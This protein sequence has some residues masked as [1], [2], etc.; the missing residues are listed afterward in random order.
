MLF[1]PEAKIKHKVGFTIKRLDVG[2]INFHYYKNRIISLIKNL[3]FPNLLYILPLHLV[4]SVGISIAFL[5][6]GQLKSAK[7]IAKAV[8]WNL[9]NITNTLKNR[10]I[11]Q[12]LRAVSDQQVFT[13]L[14]KPT[15]IRKFILDFK[16]VSDDLRKK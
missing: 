4:F 10:T 6:K 14:S 9:T 1:F 5:L 16:R 15:N 3:S 12:K 11:V 13:N 7:M 2:N 8:F